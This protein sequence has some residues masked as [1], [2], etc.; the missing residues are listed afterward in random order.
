MSHPVEGFRLAYRRDAAGAAT[1]VIALH[2]WPG[3]GA[4]YDAVR[5]ELAGAV[6][7]VVP[8]LRGFGATERPAAAPPAA[9]AA[10]GQARSVL[11]LLDELGIAPAVIVG[12]DVGSRV[13]QAI[14]RARPDAV[15]ALVLSP[16]LPGVGDRVLAPEAQA[17]FWYQS[18]HRLPLADALIDGDPAAVRAYLAHFWQHWSAPGWSP[19]PDAFERLVAGYAE[20]G[21][22]AASLGWYR[23]RA[24]TVA[25]ALRETPPRP[26]DRIRA[27]TSVLW[28]DRDPLFP[29][30]WAD[31]IDAWFADAR[32]QVL[33]GI[34]HF[35]PLEA[36]GAVAQAIRGEAGRGTP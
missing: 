22:F 5:A 3:S 34:G 8:D 19:A 21:A 29:A 30:A 2:G 15:A 11:G 20:P 18:F 28:P 23:A 9:Y 7:L 31:S 25:V 4:D 10:D 6:D 12:Y 36:P 16:P 24:G 27:P 35:L 33:E 13:A 14:A 32:L 17:E 26:E 1:P